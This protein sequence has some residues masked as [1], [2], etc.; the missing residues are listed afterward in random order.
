MADNNNNKLG[1]NKFSFYMI[2]I[3]AILY[4]VSMILALVNVSL[5][6][7][8]ALQG[9]AAACMIIVVAIL[10]WRYVRNR[11]TI[12]KVFYILC[13]MLVIVGIIVPLVA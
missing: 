8:S 5:I 10:A 11:Q 13:L 12:W 6:I 1:L 9:V 4:V 3:V 7:V 2:A